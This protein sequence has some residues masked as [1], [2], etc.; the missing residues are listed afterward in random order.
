MIE[1]GNRRCQQF[2]A[3]HTTVDELSLVLGGPA[4]ITDAS[5]RKVHNSVG[6]FERSGFDGSVSGIPVR[7]A[8]SRRS[9]NESRDIVSVGAEL[10]DQCGSDET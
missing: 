1:R 7:L 8:G 10:L 4:A 6:T 5:A 2:G 3:E 9:S